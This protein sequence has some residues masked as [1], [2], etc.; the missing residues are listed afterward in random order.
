MKAKK[1]KRVLVL[2]VHCLVNKWSGKI[3]LKVIRWSGGGGN[4]KVKKR[5]VCLFPFYFF[6]LYVKGQ[7]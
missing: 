4:Y 1:K 2:G 5:N 7:Q 3:Q 6:F